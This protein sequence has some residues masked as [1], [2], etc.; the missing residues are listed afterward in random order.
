VAVGEGQNCFQVISLPKKNFLGSPVVLSPGLLQGCSI[1]NLGFARTGKP[2]VQPTTTFFVSSCCWGTPTHPQWFI[3]L[4]LRISYNTP[5]CTPCFLFN[6]ISSITKIEKNCFL[7]EF[8]CVRKY[9]DVGRKV[10][11]LLRRSNM[12]RD[13]YG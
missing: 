3:E 10:K 11:Y 2:L 5:N 12:V 13:S 7:S 1:S 6:K 4:Y 8:Y 9:L